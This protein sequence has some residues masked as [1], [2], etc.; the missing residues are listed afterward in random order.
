MIGMMPAWR[1][2]PASVGA[3]V[4]AA[5]KD[6]DAFMK[7]ATL[8][9]ASAAA[10]IAKI[11][12]G[13]IQSG[14]KAAAE[15]NPAGV[16]AASGS[17]ATLIST[18]VALTATWTAASVVPGGQPAADTAY[19]LGIKAAAAAAASAVFSAIGGM[20][21]MHVC[22]IPVPV[23]PHGP[24]MVVKGSKSVIINNLPAARK[25][26]QVMEAC[27]GADPIAMGCPTVDIG[28]DGGGSGGSGSGG[29]GQSGTAAGKKGGISAAR[30][31]GG[32][33]GGSITPV[34]IQT[35]T[36]SCECSNPA[37]AEAFEDAADNG[38][39]LVDRDTYGC[40][41]PPAEA[42]QVVGPATHFVA[43]ALVDDEDQPVPSE[44]YNVTLPDGTEARGV[45]GENGKARIEGFEG[46]GP[47]MLCFDRLDAA[48]WEPWTPKSSKEPAKGKPPASGGK[49]HTVE[50]G[51]C[52][53]S[54]A[55][56]TGHFWQTIWNHPTNAKLKTLRGDPNLLLA[57]D[58]VYVPDHRP[59]D[60]TIA[61]DQEH[62]FRRKGEPT[63]LTLKLMAGGGPRANEDYMLEV[64]GEKRFGRT[65]GEG[66]LR[67]RIPGDAPTAILRIAGDVYTL[68]L[69]C[70]DPIRTLT[71]VQARLNN[72]GFSCGPVD[73]RL[74]PR[75]R[76]AL[77]AFRQSVGL[78]AADDID[79][80]VRK[81]LETAHDEMTVDE[82]S[83]GQ[84]PDAN[85]DEGFDPD[86]GGEE[87]RD[88]HDES[89]ESDVDETET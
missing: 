37:C 7:K 66:R 83:S 61:S 5:G 15:G 38:T 63:W 29:S 64:A 36:V 78:P 40:G 20:A 14:A 8:N 72:L 73:G 75:T 31:P 56:K 76:G 30:E 65:D 39:P 51:D 53:S 59:K 85:L 82:A 48:A 57:G 43:I 18:N 32:S 34:S 1:A 55:K 46:T 23:P 52:V 50:Q 86:V 35:M 47:C 41:G 89:E 79:D 80:A 54:I 71:G 25:D 19:T 49:T 33:E 24:G 68:D 2:L 3:A 13:L 60:E 58:Q 81:K 45:L 11:S 22:P 88:E 4:E 12:S 17:L 44:S 42:T 67:E 62:R 10:D 26:D 87:G 70:V 28:D 74:G 6:M 9:P 27:G 16:G 69:G 21:D 77:N 84:D